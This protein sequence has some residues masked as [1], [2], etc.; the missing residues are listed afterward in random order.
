MLRICNIKNEIVSEAKAFASAKHPRLCSVPPR[1]DAF[2]V[3]LSLAVLAHVLR[4]ATKS[5]ARNMQIAR[6]SRD[7]SRGGEKKKTA[8]TAEEEAPFHPDLSS[9]PV[10]QVVGPPDENPDVYKILTE[11]ELFELEHVRTKIRN[12]LE[13]EKI[14]SNSRVE[15]S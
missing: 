15:T 3:L 9:G 10:L 1:V 14:R 4:P 7:R 13:L 2:S 6:S 12:K 11:L 8:P 5:A